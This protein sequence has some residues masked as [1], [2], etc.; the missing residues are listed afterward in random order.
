MQKKLKDANHFISQKLQSAPIL[1]MQQ[2]RII[3]S[4]ILH[5]G[6]T[7]V[8]SESEVE[9]QTVPSSIKSL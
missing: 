3:M 6:N 4:G 7:D 9:L 1:R 8:E 2:R 5:N